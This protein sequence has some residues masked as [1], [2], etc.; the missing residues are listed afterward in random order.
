MAKIDGITEEG[1]EAI[2]DL[3][4]KGIHAEYDMVMM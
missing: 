4:N 2:V 3:L 1:K